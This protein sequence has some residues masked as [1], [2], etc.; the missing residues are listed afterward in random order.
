MK[1]SKWIFVSLLLLS[2]QVTLCFGD[3][4]LPDLGQSYPAAAYRKT[5]WQ[6]FHQYKAHPDQAEKYLSMLS[7]MNQ[8]LL[9]Q[10]GMKKVIAA[11]EA[12]KLADTAENSDHFEQSSEA[13]NREFGLDGEF[14]PDLK[15]HF[16]ALPAKDY[17]DLHNHLNNNAVILVLS[18]ELYSTNF[19]V[20]SSTDASKLEVLKTKDVLLRAGEISTFGAI[21]DNLHEVYAGDEGV[22]FFVV[23]TDTPDT[24]SQHSH[25]GD[26]YRSSVPIYKGQDFR[27]YYEAGWSD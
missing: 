27:V 25:D 14:I 8:Y 13:F 6:V 23:Y 19:E 5:L 1:V 15:G 10:P 9:Q 2:L 18:G 3:I 11:Y 12:E 7:F 4:V 21:R 20:S 22:L 17:Y 26:V 24:P 16:Y